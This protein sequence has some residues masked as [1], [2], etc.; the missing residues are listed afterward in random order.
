MPKFNKLWRWEFPPL[1][2]T[3]CVQ[4][5]V[6]VRASNTTLPLGWWCNCLYTY[7]GW[8]VDSVQG[9]QGVQLDL[10][11]GAARLLSCYLAWWRWPPPPQLQLQL[12]SVK[13]S[14]DLAQNNK[15]DQK[16][17]NVD[18]EAYIILDIWEDSYWNEG[19]GNW[20]F[21]VEYS[22]KLWLQEPQW[23]DLWGGDRV[24]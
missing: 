17:K 8:L 3:S 7:P 2:Q 24:C 22:V 19:G 16:K 11:G 6:C 13:L 4:C 15:D 5:T 14:S 9:V 18:C 12:S 20:L 1:V 10:G 23:G 21:W